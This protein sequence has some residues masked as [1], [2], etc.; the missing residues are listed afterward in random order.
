MKIPK[1]SFPDEYLVDNRV[2]TDSKVFELEQ[3][4]IFFT[5]LEF[6]LP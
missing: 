6:R 4:R 1:P 3:E 5:R 2:Y